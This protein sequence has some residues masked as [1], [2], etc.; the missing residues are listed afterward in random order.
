MT[1]PALTTPNLPIKSITALLEEIEKLFDNIIYYWDQL[2]FRQD[3]RQRLR[4]AWEELK[5]KP[6]YGQLKQIDPNASGLATA[7]LTGKQLELKMTSVSNV[8]QKFWLGPTDKILRELLKWLNHL[9]GSI[10]G[11]EAVKELKEA[12]EGLIN[13]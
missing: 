11:A 10:P 9:L 5:A 4:D 2:L 1:A 3:D 7:G 12:I 13:D 6:E 8:W